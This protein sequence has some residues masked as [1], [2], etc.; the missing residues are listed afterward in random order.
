MDKRR[1]NDITEAKNKYKDVFKVIEETLKKENL[2]YLVF[3]NIRPY[4]LTLVTGLYVSKYNDP[5]KLICF[6]FMCK[7][8][9][10]DFEYAI[11]ETDDIE[12]VK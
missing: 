9:G 5:K 1:I 10:S 4:S 7:K 6:D 8:N 11:A 2:E 12:L 3:D